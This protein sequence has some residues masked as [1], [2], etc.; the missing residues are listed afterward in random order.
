[1]TPAT[2]TT[3]AAAAAAAAAPQSKNLIR[4][5]AI[6]EGEK[7]LDCEKFF[8]TVNNTN[9]I[10]VQVNLLANEPEVNVVD[11]QDFLLASGARVCKSC[12][13]KKLLISHPKKGENHPDHLPSP[14]PA[15]APAPA[16]APVSVSAPCPPP[17]L[18]QLD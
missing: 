11:S 14:F 18:S 7:T 17:P 12:D 1:M 5:R 9:S 8:L 2:T 10:H 6:T 13:C 15:P 16:P 3:I 4:K